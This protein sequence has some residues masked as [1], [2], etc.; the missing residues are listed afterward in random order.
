MQ[1]QGCR[2]DVLTQKSSDNV[3]TSDQ[4]DA[5][6]DLQDA[7]CVGD[8]SGEK[9][10]CLCWMNAFDALLCYVNN[11]PDWLEQREHDVQ[12]EKR[13]VDESLFSLLDGLVV[14]NLGDPSRRFVHLPGKK[15]VHD[16][17][18]GILHRKSEAE[19]TNICLSCFFAEKQ[20]IFCKGN[21]KPSQ[22][23]TEQ[24]ENCQDRQKGVLR[25]KTNVDKRDCKT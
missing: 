12:E 23:I 5:A 18:W 14:D 6:D 15:P 20:F 17:E 10:C 9:C 13:P 11:N 21:R 3:D 1:Y 4:I 25:A 2:A 24:H 16:I 19:D 22:R 8:N 7:D